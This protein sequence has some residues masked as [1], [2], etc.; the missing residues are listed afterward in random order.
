M[1]EWKTLSCINVR[2]QKQ[3]I[4][5]KAAAKGNKIYLRNKQM[6]LGKRFL[7]VHAYSRIKR[8]RRNK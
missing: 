8:T 5:I 7:L 3:T 1:L 2:Q 4:P 6:V